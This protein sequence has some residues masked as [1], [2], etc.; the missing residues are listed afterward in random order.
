MVALGIVAGL[1]TSFSFVPR[2]IKV[3]RDGDTEVISKR[4]YLVSLAAYSLWV[5]ENR[6]TP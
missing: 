2:L 6:A 3:W 1:C 5:V 4:M